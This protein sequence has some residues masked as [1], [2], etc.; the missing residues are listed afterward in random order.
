MSDVQVLSGREVPLG[1]LRSLEVRRTLPHRE[2]AMIGAWCFADHYGP[3]PV[4]DTRRDGMD[5]APHPHTGLQTVSWLFD[6]AIEHRDSAGVVATVRPGEMNLMTSGHGIAH[7][8]VSTGDT[9]VLHGV[10]LW[11][12]L[13]SAARD[14]RRGFEHHAPRVVTLGEGIGSALVF[15]GDLPGV[16]R[17]PVATFS[18][19]LGAELRLEPGADLTLRVDPTFE[20]A[21]LVDS[22]GVTFEGQALTRGALGCVDAGRGTVRI[23][24]GDSPARLVLIGGEPFAEEIVM[25]WNFI[26]RTH[27]EVTRA[28]QEYESGSER[29]GVVPGYEP[30]TPE[31]LRRI[32]APP[33][34]PVRLRPRGRRGAG[35][36]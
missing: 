14:G 30:A 28:R 6:G 12:A 11:V 16:D 31:G 32:P 7:S 29:F 34:P 2:R 33:L 17:S 21:L 4:R 27:D 25:W 3:E 18:P 20:H 5:V 10:Q 19:L 1:G 36:R 8:E 24:V 35:H 22:G 26:G 23:V 13:P 9:Q 15:L